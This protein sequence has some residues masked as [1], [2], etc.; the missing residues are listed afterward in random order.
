M[1]ARVRDRRSP[2][3]TKGANDATMPRG[4][5][6]S[7]R[8]RN[9]DS[10]GL[11]RG[12]VDDGPVRKMPRRRSDPSRRPF[13]TDAATNPAAD[14]DQHFN[15]RQAPAE[16]AP[17]GTRRSGIFPGVGRGAAG[18]TWRRRKASEAC[19]EAGDAR[20]EGRA[21]PRRRSA[22]ARPEGRA[23]EGGERNDAERRLHVR[24]V[25][26][27]GQPG[28]GPRARGRRAGSKNATQAFGPV[29]AAFRHG[30]SDQPRGRP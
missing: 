14:P 20:P 4:G 2:A 18:L 7:D 23:Y 8:W 9:A 24:P 12:L 5:S 25:A 26:R 22:D 21:I 19:G 13:A 10:P 29:E 1:D 28:A 16:T 15:V 6:T 17:S 27:C 3:P 11:A 30:R